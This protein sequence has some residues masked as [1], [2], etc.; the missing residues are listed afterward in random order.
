MLDRSV[1]ANGAQ[2]SRASVAFALF[3]VV[4]AATLA[5]ANAAADAL[6][7]TVA[8]LAVNTAQSARLEG[9]TVI[10]SANE[11]F[12]ADDNRNAR[13]SE[14]LR[15][16]VRMALED[17]GVRTRVSVAGLDPADRA[18]E[19]VFRMVWQTGEDDLQLT[20]MAMLRVREGP[21]RAVSRTDSLPL[22]AVDAT[23]LEPDS[24]AMA[25]TLVRSL[26]A[27]TN[28]RY[29]RSVHFR[30]VDA[31]RDDGERTVARYVESWLAPA[32]EESSLF[33]LADPNVLYNQPPQTFRTRGIRREPVQEE[34]ASAEAAEAAEVSGEGSLSLAGD[35]LQADSEIVSD[36]RLGEAALGVEARVNDRRGKAV[37]F[38]GVDLPLEFLPESVIA[39]MTPQQAEDAGAAQ[40]QEEE[41][42]APALSAHAGFSHNGLEVEIATSRGE[43]RAVYKEGDSI[44]FVVRV[45]RD[46]FVYLF[47]LDSDGRA[48]LLFP[49]TGADP[50]RLSAGAPI[51]LPDDAADYEFRVRPPYGRDTVW[52]VAA[53]D[54]LT[55]PLELTEDWRESAVIRQRLRQQGVRLESGF[56]E[57]AVDVITEP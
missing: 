14:R 27:G 36:V 41:E 26:E 13:L 30:P 12:N 40:P 25:R 23:L 45:N 37:S 11:F 1:E 51:V 15:D 47:D 6:R 56:A 48:T 54:R 44:R 57:A 55:F 31:E 20:A 50:I 21:G 18:R 3:A 42:P 17:A 39:A 49:E 28:Y 29:S 22:A 24:R 33:Q 43:G 35:L 38:A 53:E 2:R 7:D 46:A 10:V 19:W 9:E 32:I 4:A 52:V 8:A 5:P 34:T 16:M